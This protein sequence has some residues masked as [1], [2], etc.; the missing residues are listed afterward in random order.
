MR[1]KGALY[2]PVSISKKYRFDDDTDFCIALID[3]L[4]GLT[5]PRHRWDRSHFRIV[6]LADTD[7]LNTAIDR[8]RDVVVGRNVG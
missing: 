2:A 7:I 4:Q 1:P 3:G 6:F 8:D 5:G